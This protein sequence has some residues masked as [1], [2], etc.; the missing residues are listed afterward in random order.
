MDTI[1]LSQKEK[2]KHLKFCKAM[3]MTRES[4][5]VP[6]EKMDGLTTF[7][8]QKIESGRFLVPQTTTILLYSLAIEVDFSEFLDK[9]RAI[10]ATL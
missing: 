9:F 8:V 2:A 3:A 7:E 5:K 4:Y 10:E 1:Q 6:I